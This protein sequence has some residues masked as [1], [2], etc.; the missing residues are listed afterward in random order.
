M[1]M[2]STSATVMPVHEVYACHDLA[3][4]TRQCFEIC[5]NGK[6]DNHNGKIDETPCKPQQPNKCPSPLVL[7]ANGNCVEPCPP[8]KVRDANG[9]CVTENKP[10]IANAGVDQEVKNGDTV[11]L[12]GA[13]S[14]DP[15]GDPI[16]YSWSQIGGEPAERLSDATSAN[17]KFEIPGDQDMVE[18]TLTFQLVVNDGKL[19]S[20][21]DVVNINFR[22]CPKSGETIPTTFPPVPTKGL[23]YKPYQVVYGRLDLVFTSLGSAKPGIRLCMLQSNVGSL[24]VML[25]WYHIPGSELQINWA[26]STTPASL[27]YYKA[28]YVS[29]IARCSWS[30]QG[31]TLYCFLDPRPS[32]P[33]DVVVKWETPG[34]IIKVNAPHSPIH[35]DTGPLTYFVNVGRLKYVTPESVN[36]V[37]G[38]I[39]YTLIKH[40]SLVDGIAVIQDPPGNN[41]LVT[42]PRG[43]HTG[44]LP[45][46]EHITEIP[47]SSYFAL[48]GITAVLL[49]K[50]PDGEYK[51]QVTGNSSGPFTLSSSFTDLSDNFT[52]M[53]IREASI[54]GTIEKDKSKVYDAYFFKHQVQLKEDTGTGPNT[55]PSTTFGKGDVF[56]AAQPNQLQW[57]SADGTLKKLIPIN[58]MH[59]A[60]TGMAFDSMDN[61]YVTEFYDAKV[62]KFSTNGTLLGTFGNFDP[63]SNPESI[64]FD[65]TGNAYVGNAGG[66]K[67][68]MKFDSNGKPLDKFAVVTTGMGSDWIDLASDQCT[69]YYTS[70]G[71]SVKKYD[72]CKHQ[73]LPD[74][75]IH[76]PNTAFALRLLPADGGLLVA[77]SGNISHLNSSGKIVQ[78]YDAPGVDDW[79]AL[80][81]DPD[82]KS[83]WSAGKHE[84]YKF[85]IA[86][87]NQLVHFNAGTDLTRIGGLV[88]NGEITAARNNTPPHPRPPNPNPSSSNVPPIANVSIDVIEGTKDVTIDGKSSND[89]DGTIA[90]YLWKQTAG[91]TITL[92]STNTAAVKFDAPSNVTAGTILRFDLTVTDN[93]GANSTS[94][95]VFIR[96]LKNTTTSPPPHN[97]PPVANAGPDQTVHQG[98][99]VTLDGSGSSDPDGDSLTYS[100]IQTAGTLV[101]LSDPHSARPTFIAPSMSV[102]NSLVF[103]LTV[104]DNGGL[105][106]SD[107]VNVKAIHIIPHNNPPVANAGPDQTAKAGST[108]RLD[109][110]ASTD[111]DPGDTLTYSWVQT[112]GEPIVTLNGADT[113]NPTFVA[114]TLSADTK[115]TFG[116]KVTD[117]HNGV[118]T[119]TVGVTVGKKN[120]NQ[121]PTAKIVI[122]KPSAPDG[123]FMVHQDDIVTL[124]GSGSSDPDGDTLTYSWVPTNDMASLLAKLRDPNA[125]TTT[126]IA[127]VMPDSKHTLTFRLTVSDGQVSSSKDAY[128]YVCFPSDT[129][130]EC[131]S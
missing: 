82:G 13:S 125:A 116:L 38:L 36:Y 46:G 130:S 14:Y 115:L 55:K 45:T 16:T 120:I 96:V 35:Y 113:A 8:P 91:P 15:D 47:S 26:T 109:G 17:P 77:D 70:E 22:F 34:F 30:D 20:S 104:T 49:F 62:S 60:L 37:E 44:I 9:N 95:T 61:L 79:F 83:F 12:D 65:N 129:R 100:W 73:Q 48:G 43:L 121:P 85:D 78:T 99:I 117:N 18:G 56:V 6:D 59:K 24:P 40:L 107:S 3:H 97:N 68:L 103:E 19:N 118:N 98:A 23:G 102:D 67:A 76:L 29:N 80:N 105:H 31:I 94:D 39:H 28:K 42:D 69:M 33:N 84:V 7:D 64:V 87:G 41:L 25:R 122:D 74:F 27:S 57:R 114:P 81:L 127:P 21:P 131:R 106:A 108:V 11:T 75:S 10:P 53:I 51:I 128:V 72:V 4:P 93:K 50:P 124:D 32:S 71:H 66:T 92:N 90:S 89:P 63:N 58:A 52:K 126:F 111:P 5:G 88:V 101:R 123:T 1:L 119:S 2:L 54:N 86:T 112:A 110:G